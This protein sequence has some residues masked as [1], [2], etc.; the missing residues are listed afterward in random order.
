[1]RDYWKGAEQVPRGSVYKGAVR[2][3]RAGECQGIQDRL[4][5]IAL[6][7]ADAIESQSCSA[8][9][10]DALLFGAIEEGQGISSKGVSILGKP[11]CKKG[12]PR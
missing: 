2:M 12:L 4:T 5:E 7:F 1:M 8:G 9:T 10:C 11:S 3:T 6:E